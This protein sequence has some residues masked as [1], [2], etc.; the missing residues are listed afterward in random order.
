MLIDAGEHV[1]KPGLR[2]DVVQLRRND[3]DLYGGTH[4]AAIGAGE[5]ARLP[6]ERDTGQSAV[7]F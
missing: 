4:P 6:Y 2:V 7:P 1:G 3:P 5:E